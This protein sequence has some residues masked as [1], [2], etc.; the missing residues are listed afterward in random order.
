MQRQEMITAMV[1]GL[2][3]RLAADGR[4]LAGWQR[5]LRAYVVLGRRQD[6]SRA[7]ADAR[8]ALAGDAGSLAV[9]DSF[10]LAL[11]LGS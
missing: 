9:L 6:A 10:A 3:R 2:A 7:L 4:D 8:R 1:E 11:G 5:L